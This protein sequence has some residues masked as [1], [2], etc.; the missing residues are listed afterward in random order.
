MKFKFLKATVTGLI[1]SVSCFLN[2]ANAG[3][4]GNL[5]HNSG[6]VFVTDSLNNLEWMHFDAA[7]NNGSVTS[8]LASFSDSNSALYGFTLAGTTYADLFLDAAFG[9]QAYPTTATGHSVMANGIDALAFLGTMG[10]GHSNGNNIWKYFIADNVTTGSIHFDWTRG[11]TSVSTT[12][13]HWANVSTN[14]DGWLND[15]AWLAYRP[16][17]VPEPSTLALFALGL[18]GLASRRFEKKS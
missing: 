18:M 12:L 9:S 8:L 14:P 6:D 3:L 13:N 1:L 4:I 5:S 10:D 2:V 15:M 16:A 11:Q 7:G 17:E